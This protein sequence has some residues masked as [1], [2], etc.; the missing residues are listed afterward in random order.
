MNYTDRQLKIIDIIKEQQPIRSKDISDIIGVSQ[1]TI[2]QDLSI[3][4]AVGVVDAKPNVGYF[5]S[6]Q[7]ATSEFY[8]QLQAVEV[9]EVMSKPVLIDE[10]SS[11]YDGTVKLILE[12]CGT[13]FVTK[14]DYLV[15]IVSRKDLLRS[16]IQNQDLKSLPIGVIMTR[17]PL[18]I[19]TPE[20][21]LGDAVR[22]LDD[23]RIDSLP[24]VE[25]DDGKYRVIGRLSKTNITN[26]FVSM[27]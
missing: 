19:C 25:E 16:A 1:A 22:R 6:E 13:L 10:A 2:R 23:G 3:L 12:D 5:Y 9:K 15:G 20:E 7:G 8:E 26:K 17:M 18:I 24:V 21:S 27:L 4:V 14:D 11:V